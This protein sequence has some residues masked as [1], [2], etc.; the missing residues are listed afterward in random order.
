MLAYYDENGNCELFHKDS[1][2][3]LLANAMKNLENLSFFGITEYQRKSQM[4]FEEIN[5]GVFKFTKILEQS[6]TEISAQFLKGLDR[7]TV[8][9]IR[10]ANSLDVRLYE[11]ALKIFNSRLQ[12]YNIRI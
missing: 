9:A 6:N 7:E 4:L 8:E 10:N 5:K 2:E 12:F 3:R 1:Q 11:H